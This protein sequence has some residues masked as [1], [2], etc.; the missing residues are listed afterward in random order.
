[1]TDMPTVEQKRSM[2]KLVNRQQLEIMLTITES[3]EIVQWI[4]EELESRKVTIQ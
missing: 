1:M 2:L 3:P 4:K